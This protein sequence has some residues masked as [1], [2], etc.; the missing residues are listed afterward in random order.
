MTY[1]YFTRTH[2]CIFQGQVVPACC[3]I[4]R[5]LTGKAQVHANCLR[6]GVVKEARILHLGCGNS[7]LTSD[8][9][10]LGYTQQTNIDFS[11]PVI[12][13]MQVKY[14]GLN[15]VWEVMDVNDMKF[16]SNSFDI[17][18]DKAT[19][20]GFFYGSPWDPTEDVR[21]SIDRYVSV[22]ARVLAPGGTFF[23]LTPRQPH[24]TKPLLAR[25]GDVRKDYP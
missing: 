2:S 23:Y 10:G 24:L 1:N 5:V 13:A 8:L 15:S 11:V 21:I 17:A 19:M 3:E 7:T 22:V 12:T 16:T 25:K 14:R 6:V 18:I 20:D 9:H 4:E